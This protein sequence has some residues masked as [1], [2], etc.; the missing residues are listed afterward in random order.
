[1]VE[2]RWPNFVH[3]N[4]VLRQKSSSSFIPVDWFLRIMYI[5]VNFHFIFYFIWVEDRRLFFFDT[6]YNIHIMVKCKTCLI[7]WWYFYKTEGWLFV[8][9]YMYIMLTFRSR[10]SL[11]FSKF[12]RLNIS[13]FDLQ[14][15]FSFNLIGWFIN[16]LWPNL[17]IVNLKNCSS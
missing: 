3:L 10:S 12:G 5:I 2:D 15:K 16:E 13:C 4:I 8:H 9:M 14:V 7:S 17:V 11:N 6:F 1:M